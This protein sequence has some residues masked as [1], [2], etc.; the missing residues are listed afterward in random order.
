MEDPDLMAGHLTGVTDAGALNKRPVPGTGLL[1]VALGCK[2]GCLSY[3]VCIIKRATWSPYLPRQ[4]LN[5]IHFGPGWL[6]YVCFLYITR[7]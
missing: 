1:I 3:Y 6:L 2:L 7:V 4:H 5:N